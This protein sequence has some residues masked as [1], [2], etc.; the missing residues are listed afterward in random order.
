[1]K[2]TLD[3]EKW[4]IND[5][6]RHKYNLYENKYLARIIGRY[7]SSCRKYEK[8]DQNLNQKFSAIMRL[9]FVWVA[10]SVCVGCM[11]DAVKSFGGWILVFASIAVMEFVLIKLVAVMFG[12]TK[13]F[14]K[15]WPQYTPEKNLEYSAESL[16]TFDTLHEKF[17]KWWKDDFSIMLFHG[18]DASLY[19]EV[20][21]GDDVIHKERLYFSKTP[22]VVVK[23]NQDYIEFDLP[24]NRIIV[25]YV[26]KE[27]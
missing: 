10:L 5:G 7:A 14:S 11:L 17:V 15:I 12:K 22:E 2:K 3:V 16:E 13:L 9:I 4:Q 8:S 1:M 25:P 20:A 18:G 26:L 19:F 24:N 21:D 23:R 6:I 27:N